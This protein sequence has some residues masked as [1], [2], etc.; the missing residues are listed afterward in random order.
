MEHNSH[1][2]RQIP[3]CVSKTA[4]ENEPTSRFHH[5]NALYLLSQGLALKASGIPG[6]SP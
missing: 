5:F 1:L 4:R 6:A 3:S 2:E